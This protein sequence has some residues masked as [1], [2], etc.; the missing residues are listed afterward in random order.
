M[1]VRKQPNGSLLLAGQTDHSRLAGQLAAHWG[2]SHF[3][4][5]DPYNSMVRAATFHDYGWL[6]YETSPLIN[7]DNGE[8][9]SFL[10]VP[11]GNSQLASYQ[12]GLDWMTSIDP[13]AGL[14][15]NMHRTGLWQ[16]RYGTITHP[17]GYTPTEM[18]A[19]VREFVKRNETWQEQ[20]RTKW[21][22]RQL[23]VN[24][25]LMQIWDL[26]A[27]YF[28]C[29]EPYEEYVEPVP[30]NYAENGGIRMTIK[31]AGP[32]KIAFDPYPFDVRP[33]RV[34]LVTRRLPKSSYE[35][36]E[37]FQR[38]YFGAPIELSEFELC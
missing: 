25:R 4:T 18:S 33:F 6:R 35:S 3:A 16:R 13:Y 10:Q 19:E 15:I 37:E 27:L 21:D 38:A 14:I 29:D 22:Q 8:P 5:P 11:L 36:V 2:N 28:C 20:A 30:I 34:Q 24:Y 32:S 26:L 12:W 17:N 31:P 23:G 7:P 9:F 1:I